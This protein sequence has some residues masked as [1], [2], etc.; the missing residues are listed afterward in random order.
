MVA[1]P[2]DFSSIRVPTLK[3]S[4]NGVELVAEDNALKAKA[5]AS[6]F[7]PPM[8]A[9]SAVPPNVTYPCPLKGMKYFSRERIYQVFKSLSPYKAPGPD[10][11]PNVVYIKCLDVLIDHLHFIYRAA[12]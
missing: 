12:M 8:P 7:F 9:T 1:E 2:T 10:G 5:L 11:I 3:C 6:S 4:Y